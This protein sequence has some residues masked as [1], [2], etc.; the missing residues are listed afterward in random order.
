M[1]RCEVLSFIGER[2]L[3]CQCTSQMIISVIS[4][5]QNTNGQNK[6]VTAATVTLLAHPSM[7]C[8]DWH[9]ALHI[10]RQMDMH[11]FLFFLFWDA[12]EILDVFVCTNNLVCSINAPGISDTNNCYLARCACRN[13]RMRKQLLSLSIK[14]CNLLYN[15]LKTCQVHKYFSNCLVLGVYKSS[16]FW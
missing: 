2:C 7:W 6:A 3:P 13:M 11:T 4:A 9:P 8:L 12:N 10:F 5:K 16:N 15:T 1:A 14:L